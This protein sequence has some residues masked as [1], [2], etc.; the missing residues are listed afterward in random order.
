MES[1]TLPKTAATARHRT[2]SRLRFIA[3]G[4][5]A[6]VTWASLPTAANAAGTPPPS[7]FL[8]ETGLFV[9]GSTFQTAP[10]VLVF[11]PQYPL[12]SDG[13]AKRRWI[14]LPPGASV[15]AREPDAWQFPIG[16]RLWK[17]FSLGRRVET[18]MIERLGDG[19][20]RF[21]VYV[22][23][24]DGSDAEL[25]PTAGLRALPV[26]GAPNGRYAVPSETDCRACH[27][28]GA[29]PVLGFSALQLSPDRDPLAPHAEPRG[30][31]DVDLPALVE[32]G[33]LRNLSSALLEQPPRIQAASPTER[34]ALGY[35]HGNCG[36][37][38]VDPRESENGV[39]LDLLLKQY[40]ARVASAEA[41]RR[42]IFGAA[43]R[44][45]AHGTR[46]SERAEIIALRMRSR[47]PR[48]Q[49]PPLGT[50]TPDSLSLSLIERWISRDL[51]TAMETKP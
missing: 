24:E 28:G 46:D 36:H 37:C 33:V 39:P 6:A 47:D 19:S 23:R 11:S 8:S 2:R 25:A 51:K 48:V 20:W 13:A 32:R 14:W 41:V 22:W 7:R 12:W 27:E 26:D 15:D 42:S 1:Q 10:G 45:R 35:L 43:S 17:E 18:R 30:A 4:L 3:S 44:F 9:A 40:V 31:S 49:M 29:A 16:T 5:V 38:H 50:Q 34:A 21:A